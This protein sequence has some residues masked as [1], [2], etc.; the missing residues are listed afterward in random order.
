MR[1]ERRKRITKGACQEG[2]EHPR[3]FTQPPPKNTTPTWSPLIL[4]SEVLMSPGKVGG[5]LM[6]RDSA[7]EVTVSCSV[8]ACVL[9]V[10][11][12]GVSDPVLVTQGERVRVAAQALQTE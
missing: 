3:G 2:G 1:R 11:H 10:E 8:C 12:V 5:L 7:S 4:P 6:E 9:M